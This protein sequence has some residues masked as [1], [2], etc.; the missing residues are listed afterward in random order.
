MI[1]CLFYLKGCDS[2]GF[3]LYLG[4]K[5][6]IREAIRVYVGARVKEK[7]TFEE[8]LQTLEAQLQNK[9]LDEFTYERV[10][11]L[12]EASFFHRQEESRASMQN[13]FL[14]ASSF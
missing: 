13:I 6:K 12:L 7:R 1:Y 2:V 14:K 10:R 9:I 5:K 8:K 11:D 4:K 3:H